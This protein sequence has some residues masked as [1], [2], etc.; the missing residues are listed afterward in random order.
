MGINKGTSPCTDSYLIRVFYSDVKGTGVA[1]DTKPDPMSEG[2]GGS[3][4]HPSLLW[5]TPNFIKRKVTS[6]A[7]PRMNCL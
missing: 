1:M 2:E 5:G 4:Q 7:C 6:Q 3:G